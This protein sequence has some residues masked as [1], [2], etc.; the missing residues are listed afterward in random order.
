MHAIWVQ[1]GEIPAED[2]TPRTCD[3]TTML[4]VVVTALSATVLAAPAAPAPPLPIPTREIA[5]GVHL[6]MAGLG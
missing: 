2:S 6:P 1:V 5:P 4:T 3:H